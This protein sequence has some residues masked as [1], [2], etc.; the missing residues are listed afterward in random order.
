MRCFVFPLVVLLA[1]AG[2][3]AESDRYPSLLPRAVEL[4][5][6]AG[7]SP[8]PAPPA[9]PDA[10]LDARIAALAAELDEA[11]RAFAAAAQAAEA[12]IAVA[13]GT[14]PGS[15]AWLD[16]QAALATL[17]TLRAPALNVLVELEQ[18]AIARG[19]AGQPSY[20]ALTGAIEA[21]QPVSQAQGA[22]IAAL[23]AALGL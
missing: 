2:C 12:R 7:M 15:D 8:A 21:A 17:D 11:Q 10:A 3:S 20:P 18:L 5:D 4:E 6:A 22:R 14:A 23:E 19:V 9:T 16:A 1:T 13:R